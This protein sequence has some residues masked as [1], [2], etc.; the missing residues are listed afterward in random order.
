MINETITLGQYL[1]I[2]P[3]L[4]LVNFIFIVFTI[5]MVVKIIEDIID[6]TLDPKSIYY[7]INLRVVLSLEFLYFIMLLHTL[8]NYYFKSETY[9]FF[10]LLISVFIIGNIFVF[11]FFMNMYLKKNI[12]AVYKD[13]FGV[14]LVQYKV[15]KV[16]CSMSYNSYKGDIILIYFKLMIPVFAIVQYIFIDKQIKIL[17]IFILISAYYMYI[18]MMKYVKKYENRQ[19][20]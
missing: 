17:I 15:N 12:T 13:N 10:I 4:Q 1:A 3:S 2:I 8:D 18:E 7:K 19:I 9:L 6:Y 14:L 11:N 16:N 5:F 20:I